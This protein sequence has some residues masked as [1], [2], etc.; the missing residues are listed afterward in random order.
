MPL[1]PPVGGGLQIAKIRGRGDIL[2]WEQFRACLKGQKWLLGAS[3][4]WTTALQV[5]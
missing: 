3:T 5:D 1:W 2:E 4:D